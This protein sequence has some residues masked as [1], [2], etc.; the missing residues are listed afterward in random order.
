MFKNRQYVNTGSG[1]S[2]NIIMMG[3]Y[4]FMRS[5][6]DLFKGTKLYLYDYNIPIW[7][8]D[9]VLSTTECEE[10]DP[11]DQF[12]KHISVEEFNYILT[13]IKTASYDAGVLDTQKSIKDI[14]GIE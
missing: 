11:V 1:T 13:S 2:Y 5:N 4:E 8:S 9:K 7:V 14:L 6:T 3:E 12:L 10:I